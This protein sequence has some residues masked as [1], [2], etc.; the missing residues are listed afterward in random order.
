MHPQNNSNKKAKLDTI[1]QQALD[2][3]KSNLKPVGVDE[4]Q[5]SLMEP[6]VKMIAN[7]RPKTIKSIKQ[8]RIDAR[9]N[10]GALEEMMGF[11]GKVGNYYI[12]FGGVGDVILLLAEAYRDPDA[13]IIFYANQGSLDFAKLFLNEFKVPHF[14]RPNIMG[15][16]LAN[17]AVDLLRS[18]G[19]LQTSAHL[20]DGLDYGDWSRNQEKYR[21]RMPKKTD[22]VNKFGFIPELKNK[23]IAI[24]APSG[25]Y[26]TNWKQKYLHIHE[27]ELLVDLYLRNGYIVYSTGSD[28]DKNYY[29]NIRHHA[30]FW[31]TSDKIYNGK[32]FYDAINFK[33][34]IQIINS[35]TEVLSVD[36]WIKT[37]SS[38]ANIPTK[39]FENRYNGR[40]YDF[41]RDSGD[42]VFLNDEWWDSMKRYKIEDF[43][44][45]HGYF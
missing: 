24:I 36:T 9:R 16:S 15:T 32:N 10:H 7:T 31:L 25:S 23:K 30:H 43:L 2:E 42:I 5:R 4:L 28:A 11:A 26:R 18:T 45:N 27:Y 37:Y 13:K 34:F 38:L 21:Q 1:I 44:Q 22:W 6:K 17:T 8:A 39:V 41:G 19:R 14:V 29:Q 3:K 20:P 12:T 40:I 33:H 35:A